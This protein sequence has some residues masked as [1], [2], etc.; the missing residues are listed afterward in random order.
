MVKISSLLIA[1]GLAAANLGFAQVPSPLAVLN[2]ASNIP[3]GLPISGI[4]QGS[5]FVIYGSALGPATLAQ[6]AALPL[7]TTTGLSGTSVQVSVSGITVTAPIVYTSATQVAGVLP[8]NTPVGTGTISVTYNGQTGSTPIT[9]VASNFGISTVNQTGAGPAVVTRPDYS[10]ISLTNSVRPGET[11]VIWGTGLGPIATDDAAVPVPADLGTPIHVFLGTQEVKVIYRGRSG[12]PGL[13]QINVVVPNISDLGCYVSLLIQTKSTVSNVTTVP[14]A[15][16]G[17]TCTDS[18]GIPLTELNSF[19]RTGSVR[20]GQVVVETISASSPA[21]GPIQAGTTTTS[22]GAASFYKYTAAQLAQSGSLTGQPS[23]GS[24][25]ISYLTANSGSTGGTPLPPVAG[26][27]TGLNAG[28]SIS[29]A[30]PIG[31]TMAPVGGILGSYQATLKAALPGGAY[32]LANGAG[33]PDVGSF[34][35]ITNFPAS[36]EWTN[37]GA[38]STVDR[39]APFTLTWTGGDPAGYVV[40]VGTSVTT[41]MPILGTSFICTAQISAGKFTIPAPVLLSLPPSRIISAGGISIPT[42]ILGLASF[43][44]L[45]K[46]QAPG[47]DYA[48]ALSGSIATATITYK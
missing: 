14:V 3:A 18:T 2:P 46:F 44:G 37:Q 9:V 38:A 11:I 47:L 33:G 34:S 27:V 28:A 29:F 43:S 4:A 16:V 32:S 42:G 39:T 6:A 10:V 19:L 8:S 25:S 5:I 12:F 13:D 30:G 48:Y 20:I 15:A 26:T 35:T 1:L 17:G 21:I 22:I 41:T 45:Q 36:L 24:C 23:T 31:F 7:P 40:I